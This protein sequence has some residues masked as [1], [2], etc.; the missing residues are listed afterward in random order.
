MEFGHSPAPQLM[1]RLNFSALQICH[2]ELSRIKAA[3]CLIIY[4]IAGNLKWLIKDGN[5]SLSSETDLSAKIHSDCLSA[6]LVQKCLP[7][8][9]LLKYTWSHLS[10]LI[11]DTYSHALPQWVS[12]REHMYVSGRDCLVIVKTKISKIIYQHICCTLGS[13]NKPS[14]WPWQQF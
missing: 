7:H 12:S 8:W 4:N 2:I 6:G 3:A 14:A 9:R 11:Q 1:L 10:A 13:I 5:I